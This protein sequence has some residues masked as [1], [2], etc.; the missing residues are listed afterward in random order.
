[1]GLAVRVNDGGACFAGE[2][3]A[4]GGVPGLVAEGDAGVQAP[5][6]DPGQVEGGGAEHPDPVDAG[7]ELDGGGEV[8][9]VLAVGAVAGGVVADRD[10][11]VA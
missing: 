8:G 2:Q 1:M 9:L 11:R 3:D 4:C 7:G 5:G 10:D 6:G